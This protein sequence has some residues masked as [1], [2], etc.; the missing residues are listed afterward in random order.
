MV[1]ILGKVR[2]LRQKERGQSV[3]AASSYIFYSHGMS[4]LVVQP[5]PPASGDFK[6]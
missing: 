2:R 5:F 4:N 6:R 1:Y 3:D